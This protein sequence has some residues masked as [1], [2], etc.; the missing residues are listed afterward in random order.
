[1]ADI[2]ET[3]MTLP[4]HAD[5]PSTSTSLPT[6]LASPTL[7]TDSSSDEMS[8]PSRRLPRRPKLGS[9]KSSGSMIIPRDSACVERDPEDEEYDEEDCRTMSPRRSSEAIQKLG[10]DARQ[11]LMAYVMAHH[12]T[13]WGDEECVTSMLTYAIPDRRRCCKRVCLR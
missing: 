8:L 9:R 11:S 3:T 2:R 5:P 13:P 7:S 6:N 1:M 12:P 4:I 10:E